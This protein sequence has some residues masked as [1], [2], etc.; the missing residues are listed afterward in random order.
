MRA[1]LVLGCALAVWHL[2]TFA[3]PAVRDGLELTQLTIVVAG[4]LAEVLAWAFVFT[5]LYN[6]TKSTL[7]C[8][9]LHG[10]INA[11]AASLLLAPEALEGSVYLQV[12]LTGN[13]TVL[14][15][16][17]ALV[18]LTRGRLGPPAGERLPTPDLES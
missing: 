12:A 10:G 1:T 3:F 8:I 2:P 11:A 13:A 6:H 16:A 14:A 18:M 17:V 15:G 9:L 5:W 4:A 7:L